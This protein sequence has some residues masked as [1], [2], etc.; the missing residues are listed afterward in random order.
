[1]E[2][3]SKTF[4]YPKEHSLN[5]MIEI[6]PSFLIQGLYFDDDEKIVSSPGPVDVV[7]HVVRVKSEA[8]HVV[9][10]NLDGV[11]GPSLGVGEGVQLG[12]EELGN[13]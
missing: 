11:V 8:G 10:H 6:E 4:T 2:N 5:Q 7:V 12:L 13:V 9:D 3:L 1:M